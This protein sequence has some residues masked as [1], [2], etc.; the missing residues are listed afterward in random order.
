MA[1]KKVS[2]IKDITTKYNLKDISS[3][4]YNID[5]DLVGLNQGIIETLNKYDLANELKG[6][7][8]YTAQ[9]RSL[10][11][12]LLP[13]M[14]DDDRIFFKLINHRITNSQSIEDKLQY[15]YQE[16]DTLNEVLT[17]S[18]TR[19]YQAV[20]DEK[21]GILSEYIR[22]ELDEGKSFIL[23]I[24]GKPRSGKSYAG[25]RIALNVSEDRFEIGDSQLDTKD[26]IYKTEKYYERREHRR[27]N[28][29]LTY[30]TQQI[31][32]AIGM[33]DADKHYDEEVRGL[34]HSVKTQQV[35]GNLVIFVT[36]REGDVAKKLREEFHAILEP[37]YD[38]EEETTFDIK[39]HKNW[40]KRT[41]FSKWQFTIIDQDLRKRIPVALGRVNQIL[42]KIPPTEM[43]E[44]YEA[45]S[46]PFKVE[47]QSREKE[48]TQRNTYG[49]GVL[50]IDLR[51]KIDEIWQN[52]DSVKNERGKITRTSIRLAHP[53]IP[54]EVA[55][56]ISTGLKKRLREKEKQEEEA[57]NMLG[58]KD[59]QT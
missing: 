22:S 47:V 52:L 5:Y 20:E 17:H 54:H 50:E 11:S 57:K 23:G 18:K 34:I 43:V 45:L 25:M 33:V 32:E 49:K 53:Y 46:R 15:L 19:D 7:N 31:D 44:K 55:M 9:L 40:D 56:M 39:K 36:P 29:T 42:I 3:F 8:I 51:N 21:G 35:E 12:K 59:G 37:F 24:F 16:Y 48:K 10:Q 6:L 2:K 28:N 41:G 38:Y 58:V 13:R 26:V 27:K 4:K 14:E 30:S 1:F